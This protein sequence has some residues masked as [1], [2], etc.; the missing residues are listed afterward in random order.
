M[1]INY[2]KVMIFYLQFTAWVSVSFCK[3]S[4][5]SQSEWRCAVPRARDPYSHAAPP[6]GTTD[7]ARFF[8][9]DKTFFISIFSTLQN[10]K[11]IQ[12]K[13]TGATGNRSTPVLGIVETRRAAS[14]QGG[15][16]R[17]ALT[18]LFP[19]N[20]VSCN[21]HNGVSRT[22]R[23]WRRAPW[24]FLGFTYFSKQCQSFLR[25]IIGLIST[26]WRVGIKHVHIPQINGRM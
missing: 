13:K 18:L 15:R 19:F 3:M 22:A 17:Y 24:L 6:V 14:L 4:R 9:S 8:M 2:E 21:P 12:H 5:T 23:S 26:F 1:K 11:I 20:S 7:R 10:Y 25:K 16:M